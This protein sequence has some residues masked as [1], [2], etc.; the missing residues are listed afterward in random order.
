MKPSGGTNYVVTCDTI[1]ISHMFRR[2]MNVGSRTQLTIRKEAHI[3]CMSFLRSEIEYL[4]TSLTWQLAAIL[5][6][7]C[8]PIFPR[9][10]SWLKDAVIFCGQ[11]R[12][13]NAPSITFP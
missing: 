8:V 12:R 10:L 3:T 5:K 9:S 11:Q 2:E 13:D 4:M 1:L 7:A 6:K